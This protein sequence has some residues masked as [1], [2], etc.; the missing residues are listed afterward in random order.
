LLDQK[1]SPNSKS[2]SLIMGQPR[3]F[4]SKLKE[5][6]IYDKLIDNEN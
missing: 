3:N 4:Y 6:L 1:S 5:Y 2:V